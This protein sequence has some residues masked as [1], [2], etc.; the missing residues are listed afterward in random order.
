MSAFFLKGLWYEKLAFIIGGGV[1]SYYAGPWV[2]ATLGLPDG[3]SG[4]LSG[5]FGMAVLSRAWEWVQN[6][7]IAALWAW[8]LDWLPRRK[9]DKK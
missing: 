6:T 5:L 3:L 2:S 1:V 4:F 9:K 8:A 7:P